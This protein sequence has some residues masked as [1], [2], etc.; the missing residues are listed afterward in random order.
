MDCADEKVHLETIKGRKHRKGTAKQLTRI[1][2]FHIEEA[3]LDTLFQ[4]D[5]EYMRAVDISRNCGLFESWNGSSWIVTG[6]LY[7]LEKDERAEAR[8]GPGGQRSGWKL[9]TREKNRRAN[10]SN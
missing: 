9:T 8:R 7:K 3:I 2:V 4:A 6:T 10:I 1:G 5:E